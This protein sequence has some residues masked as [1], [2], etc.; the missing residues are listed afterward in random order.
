VTRLEE[1]GRDHEGLVSDRDGPVPRS[2]L[3]NA[4][5]PRHLEGDITT[6]AIC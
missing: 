1:L 4:G 3:T 5:T 6:A 2:D